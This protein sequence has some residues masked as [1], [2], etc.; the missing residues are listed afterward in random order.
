MTNANPGLSATYTLV[1]STTVGNS[2]LSLFKEVRNVTTGGPWGA[3]NQ[4]KSGQVLEYRVT[5]TNTVTTPMTNV[6]VMDSVPAYTVFQ[7]A[8]A[9]APTP[10]GLGSC[11]KNTPANAVPAPAVGCAALQTPG[12]TGSLRWMFDGVLN[13]QATGSVGFTVKVD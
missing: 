8:T 13:P 7:A 4:A 2:A 10:L 11:T 9:S 12:G 6:V 3:D 1:D 5:Y